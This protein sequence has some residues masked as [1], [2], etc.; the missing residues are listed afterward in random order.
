MAAPDNLHSRVVAWLKVVL[1]LMA[2]ALLS[3]LFLVART[4]DRN[5]SLPFSEKDLEEMASEQRVDG[6]EF[7]GVTEEGHAINLSARTATPRDAKGSV[8]DAVEVNGTMETGDD[9]SIHL[10]S[11]AGTVH[12]TESRTVLRGNVQV[13]T[14]TGYQIDTDELTAALDRTDIKTTGAVTASGPIG[15]IDAGR[16]VVTQ[17]GEDRESVTVV[18][19]DGVRLLYLP[20]NQ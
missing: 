2:L 6:P 4:G 8:V 15:T 12:A 19:K 14:S 5:A 13:T 16:M 9:S 11:D 3:S 7:S 1:P 17:S 20:R 10:Q 18:F